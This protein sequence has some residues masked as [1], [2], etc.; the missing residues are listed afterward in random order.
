MHFGMWRKPLVMC[1]RAES[2][3]AP[4]SL[5]RIRWRR[6]PSTKVPTVL[7]MFNAIRLSC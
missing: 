5:A 6:A 2:A 1:P 3:E 4:G 7:Q